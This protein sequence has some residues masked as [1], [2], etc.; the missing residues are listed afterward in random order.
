MTWSISI[1]PEGWE[2][3]RKKVEEQTDSFLRRALADAKC[4]R[5]FGAT[6]ASTLNL[7]YDDHFIKLME[8]YRELPHDVLVNA[9]MEEVV[10]TNTCD[11]GGFNYWIDRLGCYIIKLEEV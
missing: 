10:K 3:I 4:Q 6:F 5:R 9:V 2:D 8:S 1:S 7:D 11:S